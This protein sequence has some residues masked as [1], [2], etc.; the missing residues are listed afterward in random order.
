M[1][2]RRR[3]LRGAAAC[4]CRAA[5]VT[6]FVL[7]LRLGQNMPKKGKAK[8]ADKLAR[9]DA[10]RLGGEAEHSGAAVLVARLAIGLMVLFGVLTSGAVDWVWEW[11]ASIPLSSIRSASARVVGEWAPERLADRGVDLLAAHPVASA[12]AA[13]TLALA[14]VGRWLWRKRQLA[15]AQHAKRELLSQSDA[16]VRQGRVQRKQAKDESKARGREAAEADRARWMREEQDYRR[17]QAEA[18]AHRALR[19]AGA[20]RQLEEIARRRADEIAAYRMHAE[21]IAARYDEEKRLLEDLLAA[22]EPE[23]WP[24]VDEED[25]EDEEEDVGES[26]KEGAGVDV[27]ETHRA[28]LV[29]DAHPVAQGTAISLGSVE[30]VRVATVQVE[31]LH[32]AMAC[33]RCEQAVDVQLSGLYAGENESRTWCGHCSALL[34]V[35]LRPTLV[36]AANDV[37]GHLDCTNCRAVDCTGA[38]LLA[39]CFECFETLRLPPFLRNRR[40][41]RNC[42]GA[43]CHVSLQLRHAPSPFSLFRECA[44]RLSLLREGAPLACGAYGDRVA[45]MAGTGYVHCLLR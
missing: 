15:A 42:G 33:C 6:A 40:L 17:R 18:E 4:Q 30:L 11:L 14:P 26:G 24:E 7:L 13:A 38:L 10:K 28:P 5:A 23:D 44:Y 25:E 35:T 20:Q 27:A 43:N 2:R 19:R 3:R 34:S 31:T 41:E 12:G 16:E 36:H 22:P 29:L 45:G 8:T 9:R 32:V 39:T 21:A 37:L 1:R